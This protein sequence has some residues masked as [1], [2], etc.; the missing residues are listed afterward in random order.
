MTR[1]VAIIEPDTNVSS[2][3]EQTLHNVGFDTA[4]LSDGDLYEAIKARAPSVILLNVELMR[5]SGYSLCNRLKKQSELKRIPIIL[6][7]GQETPEAFAQHAKSATPADAYI[8]KPFSMDQLLDAVGRLLP[9]VFPDGVPLAEGV[10]Q[11]ALPA[12]SVP[13][14]ETQQ[15][16]E[17][18]RVSPPP[19][20]G[21]PASRAPQGGR[22]GPSLD[23]LL[24]HGRS[25]EPNPAPAAAAGPEAKLAF[26]RESLRRREQELTKARELWS[27]RERE[28]GQLTEMLDLREREFERARKAREDL[29]AQLTGAEDRIAALRL[30]VELGAERADRLE[31]EKK[32]L[33]EE[34]ESAQLDFDSTQEKLSR[35]VEELGTALQAEQAARADD[36]DRNSTEIRDLVNDLDTA[37]A[38]AGKREA[39]AHEREAALHREIAELQARAAELDVALDTLKGRL[40]DQTVEAE[41]VRRDLAALRDKKEKDDAAARELI[42][43]IEARLRDL[44]LDKDGLEDE[45]HKVQSELQDTTARLDGEKNRVIDLEADLADAQGQLSDL[46]SRLETSETRAAEQDAE[47][48]DL[49]AYAQKLNQD[50]NRLEQKLTEAQVAAKHAS[51]RLETVQ[52]EF[53][54]LKKKATSHVRELEGRVNELKAGLVDRDQRLNEVSASLSANEALLRDTET[55]LADKTREW[56][57]ERVGRQK[58][59]FKRDQRIADV[60][61]K[62]KELDAVVH[63]LERQ[64][65][66]REAALQHDLDAAR[67]RG[68]ELDRDFH[69][70][71][72]QGA[73]LEALVQ[74]G[75][76]RVTELTRDLRRV[77]GQLLTAREE[78][79]GA[80]DQADELSQQLAD[81]K[82][83]NG[84]LES[85]LS[86][87]RATH[88]QD[89]QAQTANLEKAQLQARDRIE[90]LQ[91]AASRYK[92]DLASSQADLEAARERLQKAEDRAQKLQAHVEREQRERQ[93]VVDRSG[94][95]DSALEQAQAKVEAMQDEITRLKTIAKKA[96]EDAV[97]VKKERALLEQRVQEDQ[98]GLTARLEEQK[99]AAQDMQARARAE[100]DAAK[101]ERDDTKAQLSALRHKAESLLKRAKENETAA[102]AKATDVDHKLQALMGDLRSEKE[103]RAREKAQAQAQA[104]KLQQQLAESSQRASSTATAELEQVRA[105]LQDKDEKLARSAAEAAQYKE[106]ARD[107]ISKAREMEARLK[108]GG[109]APDE[110]TKRLLDELRLK[111]NDAVG[112]LKAQAELNKKIDEKYR[113]LADKHRK[114]LGVIDDLKKRPSTFVGTQPAMPMPPDDDDDEGGSSQA[115]MVLE[116]PFLKNR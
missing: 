61:A 79:Q 6:T 11:R 25:D 108:A 49:K 65:K 114:A 112:K 104:D 70:A 62:N 60:E 69:R 4:V 24:A 42:A 90:K 78:L 36:N 27:S 51:D 68:D 82:E 105:Q 17:P 3:V 35:R 32:A 34:L 9:E 28:M 23:E 52:A 55:R 113:E 37:R 14:E 53:D 10:P 73:E 54:E 58:D 57:Q 110:A 44:G 16:T 41:S 74:D 20:P 46:G 45:L 56:D 5:G 67:A 15:R 97:A 7:S 95:L 47:L 100:I 31:R 29:L 1:T 22:V 64:A 98:S 2:H 99:S 66:T 84:Y 48:S 93:A 106:K 26:L 88:S 92:S 63:D 86:E 33:S 111:Y 19:R 101:K 8:H 43:D 38:E 103:A 109:G 83:R 71:R 107:V 72:A 50:K 96:Q 87:A 77:E 85:E 21:A 80:T 76:D 12:D 39:S 89:V 116:N 13:L 115:T 94:V 75:K 18:G 40:L 81:L 59:V 102:V 30:D 91:E